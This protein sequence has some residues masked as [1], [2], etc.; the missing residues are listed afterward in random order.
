MSEKIKAVWGSPKN[1]IRV[2]EWL[3]SQGAKDAYDHQCN[4][5]GMLYYADPNGYTKHL[6]YSYEYLF[7]IEEPKRWR[8]DSVSDYYYYI[9]DDGNIKSKPEGFCALD[10]RRY[11][12]GNYFKTEQE[13]EE[14]CD[15]IR[16][17]LIDY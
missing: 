5:D 14:Y 1:P 3:E 16:D 7:D 6:D 13:A 15:R 4:N 11:E 12:F 8:A 10:D 2:K 17:L 9:A